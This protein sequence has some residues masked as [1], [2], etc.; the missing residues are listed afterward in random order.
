MFSW[1][2][3]KPK[4][5][6]PE[7]KMLA[8]AKEHG[9]ETLKRNIQENRYY[10]GIL[11][12]EYSRAISTHSWRAY[13]PGHPRRIG[14]CSNAKLAAQNRPVSTEWY[15][16]LDRAKATVTQAELGFNYGRGEWPETGWFIFYIQD[17][18]MWVYQ[19]E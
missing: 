19:G 14:F 7:G 1:F 13:P 5:E 11:A 9:S 18:I 10:K 8:W 4:P 2:K 17:D 3:K 16:R 6:S 12:E 15:A